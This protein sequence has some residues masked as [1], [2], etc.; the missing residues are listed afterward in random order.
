MTFTRI[1][2]VAL[3]FFCSFQAQAQ[4][5]SKAQETGKKSSVIYSNAVDASLTLHSVTFLPTTDNMGG[6]FSKP[7]DKKLSEL[8]SQDS[9][10]QLIS[11]QFAGTFFTPADL[12][13]DPSKVLRIAK[14]LKADGVIIIDARRNPQDFLV[15]LHLFSARDGKLITQVSATDIDQNSMDKALMQLEGL[16]A[17]MKSKIP[18]DGMILSRTQNRVTVNLGSQ[19]GVVAGQELTCAK[20]IEVKRHPKTG[21][22]LQHEKAILGK[23]KLLKVDGALSFG[24]VVTEVE[25]GAI[26]KDTKVVGARH[27]SHNKENWIDNKYVPAEVLLSKNNE[28]KEDMTEWRPEMPPTFGQISAS[29]GLSNFS[30][31]LSLADGT[32]LSTNTHVFPSINLAA[33]IWINPEWYVN[34]G[35]SQGTG[36]MNNPGANS[37]SELNATLSQYWIDLGYN[38]L[39]KD[40]FFDSKLFAAIGYYDYNMSLDNSTDGLSS[41]EYKSF[42]I[43]LGGKTPIDA[44]ER[45]YMGA[46]LLL[47]LGA[48]LSEKPQTSGSSSDNKI[49]HFNVGLD[50]RY[51]ERVWIN[52]ALDFKTFMSDFS[53]AGSRSVNGTKNSEK[54]QTLQ[55][56][57]SY[58]F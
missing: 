19:D 5:A 2:S 1:F 35:M 20:I 9:Q 4:K 26:Q 39:L 10:W 13:K 25:N 15:A 48:D 34:V 42:R 14:P 47:Y 49:V 36:S 3:C 22:I 40:S 29:L 57:I 50:Y 46:S 38:L 30:R 12:I 33:E 32:S 8:L 51:S 17:Q 6:V 16:Y 54:F 18:Y 53:G 44:H 58:M 23:I 43:T 31:T 24:D 28:K 45:W 21:A 55:A 7:F 11:S 41:T 27:V 37:P 52:T 56:G